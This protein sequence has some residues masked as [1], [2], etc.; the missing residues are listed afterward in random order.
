M[1]DDRTAHLAL[2]LPHPDNLLDEDVQR[3]RQ[4]IAGLEDAFVRQDARIAA[5]ESALL[6]AMRRQRLRVFHRFDF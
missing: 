3:L 2:P 5:G 1:I 6:D 4:A